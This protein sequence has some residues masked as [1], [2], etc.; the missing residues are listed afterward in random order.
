[1]AGNRTYIAYYVCWH[2]YTVYTFRQCN[3]ASAFAS[4][5][6]PMAGRHIIVVLCAY[7]DGEKLVYREICKVALIFL[8]FNINGIVRGTVIN[9]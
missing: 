2:M 7:T 1:M 5:L 9:M 8:I 4:E 3:R 6:F